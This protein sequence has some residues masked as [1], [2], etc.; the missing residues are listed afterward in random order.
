MS[1]LTGPRRPA[2]TVIYREEP[3]RRTPPIP[4]SG[5]IAWMRDNLFSSWLDTILTILSSLLITYL[6]VTFITW[7]IGQ[8]NWF[9]ISR[10]MG[11]YMVGTLQADP[12]A[13]ERVQI[14]T[15]I[16]AAVVGLSLGA[17]TRHISRG[18]IAVLAVLAVLLFLAPPLI[19]AAIPLPPTYLAAGDIT[20]VSGTDQQSPESEVA[21]I[22]RA[23][24]TIRIQMTPVS[25][26]SLAQTVGFSDRTTS[27]LTNVATARLAAQQ[28]IAELQTLLAADNLNEAER[29]AVETELTSIEGQAAAAVT[30]RYAINE[31]P[32]QIEILDGSSLDVLAEST[33]TAGGPPLILELPDDGWYILR[34]QVDAEESAALLETYGLYPFNPRQVT[35][36]L[37]NQDGEPVLTSSG[38][39]RTRTV[40]EY[41]RFTDEYT[42]AAVEPRIEGSTVP[43]FSILGHQYQGFR[44]LSDWLVLHFG[45]FLRQLARGLIPIGLIALAGYVIAKAIDRAQNTVDRRQ[46][47]SLRIVRWAWFVLPTVIFLLVWTTD[48]TRWGGLFLTFMLTVVGIVA[49]F[50]IGVMLALGRRS[51]GVPVIQKACVLFIEFVRGVPLITVLFLSSLTL[52]LVS[53]ALS[54]VS[55]VVRAMVAITL[56]SAAYLAENVRGG[57]Q[58]IPP[59]QTEAAKAL[60]MNNVQ[61]T[62]FITLPQALRAVIPALVGQFIALFK[63]TS[64][65]AIVG[66]TD[67]TGIALAVVARAEFN[68]L[69]RESFLFISLIY[70]IFSYAMSYVSR[71]LEDSGSGATRRAR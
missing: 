15:L 26:L 63:D 43:Q 41:V 34:K 19:S 29:A 13:V 51:H 56:F 52:P 27:T 6:L 33:L 21:F 10:N 62:L 44:P 8:A 23:G 53:P 5:I 38:Q 61:V 14:M 37:L 54:T 59:G 1:T 11:L 28:R 65:V 47:L 40:T 55:G 57:L 50:P 17:W 2:D 71:R 18:L 36:P 70:F 35:R 4:T 7:A 32:V 69:R 12:T 9:V 30:E 31:A 16:I 66:L 22:G 24:E 45:P 60:G 67:L 42:T 48:V 25:E 68:D 58:S 39:P 20:V 3:A 49:S 46:R 64:L